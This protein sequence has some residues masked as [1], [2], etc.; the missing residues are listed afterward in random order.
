MDIYRAQSRF[1][2]NKQLKQSNL[3]FVHPKLKDSLNIVNS[4]RAAFS[5]KLS[6]EKSNFSHQN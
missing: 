6:L 4:A 5:N 3:I 2:G 1:R